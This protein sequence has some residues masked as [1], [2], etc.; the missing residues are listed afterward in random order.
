MIFSL[1]FLHTMLLFYLHAL[2]SAACTGKFHSAHFKCREHAS[3][4]SLFVSWISGVRRLGEI[5]VCGSMNVDI[6]TIRRAGILYP[7]SRISKQAGKKRA[8][9]STHFG[10]IRFFIRLLFSF[11]FFS[12]RF[13]QTYFSLHILYFSH[14]FPR[15]ARFIPHIPL[16]PYPHIPLSQYPPVPLSPISHYPTFNFGHLFRLDSSSNIC[17][18]KLHPLSPCLSLLPTNQATNQAI[19]PLSQSLSHSTNPMPY[20]LF[21]RLNPIFVTMGIQ[22]SSWIGSGIFAFGRLFDYILSSEMIVVYHI[23][24]YHIVS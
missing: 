14:A 18:W 21:N 19:P 6:C 4:P 16:S 2:W 7:E 1:L 15:L 9:S 8:S 3:C 5:E 11:L 12:R 23:V 22:V 24:S 10:T 20:S 17:T 13:F